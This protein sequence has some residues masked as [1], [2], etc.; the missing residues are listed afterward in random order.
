MNL[1]FFFFFFFTDHQEKIDSDAPKLSTQETTADTTTTNPVEEPSETTVTETTTETEL[2]TSIVDP[3]ESKDSNPIEPKDSIVSTDDR[4]SSPEGEEPVK[5][6]PLPTQSDQTQDIPPS[7]PPPLPPK[8]ISPLP[9]YSQ[10][11]HSQ[12]EESIYHLKWFEWKGIQTPI[13]TQNEN[14]PCPLLAIANVLILARKIDLPPMQQIISGKQLMEYI[15][16]RNYYYLDP[17]SR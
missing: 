6:T 5:P 7:P 3:I 15:G 2:S 8:T 11:D 12:Q 13:V 16:K 1:I 9:P 4:E 17:P 14:G 10:G